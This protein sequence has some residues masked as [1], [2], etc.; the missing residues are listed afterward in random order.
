MADNALAT[1]IR[2]FFGRLSAFQ[3]AS[4]AA[5]LIL[6]IAGFIYIFTTATQKEMSVLYSGLEQKEASTIVER[7]KEMNVDYKLQDEGT[8]ILVE[9]GKIHETRLQLAGEGL[10]ET[11]IVGYEIFDRTN[12]GM[13]EFVQKVNYRRALEGELS[14]TIGT[15]EEIEKVRVHIVIPEK[16]LFEKDQKMPTASVILNLKSGRSVSKLNMQGIQ[17]LVANSVEGMQAK[18]VSVVDQR[19]KL[20]SKVD[21]KKGGIAGM[22]ADQYEQKKQLEMYLKD[23]AQS[24]LQ[25]V[26]GAGNSEVRVSA[27][28]DF[29]Q[30][31]ETSTFYDPDNVVE[32]SVQETVNEKISV[33]SLTDSYVNINKN[34]T[35]TTNPRV[36]KTTDRQTNTIINNEVSKKVTRIVGDIGEIKRLTVTAIVNQKFVEY[37]ENGEPVYDERKPEEMDDLEDAI[38]LAIGFDN[39]QRQDEIHV[40]Q[41]PFD[42]QLVEPPTALKWWE[43]PLNRKLI[44]LGVL[45]LITVLVLYQILRSR[46]IKERVR[47]A[48]SLPKDSEAPELEEKEDLED[49]VLE[50]EDML[51]LPS[52]MPEQLLL[53]GEEEAKALESQGQLPEEEEEPFDKTSLA[54][55]AKAKLEESPDLTEEAMLKLE[56]KNKVQDYVDS[57]TTDA[58][59]LVRMFMSQDVLGQ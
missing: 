39:A 45:I 31:E 57:D 10:P 49:I 2:N 15:M 27:E 47:M 50:E 36:N 22:S 42:T 38:K 34:E 41:V 16:T 46:Q 18:N 20:L 28:L 30:N 33:D 56:I 19:G 35:K 23:K 3:K 44:L 53:E 9:K 59:K 52:E 55:K 29:S 51:M 7:L 14:K 11:G 1:Q 32:R 17:N 54:D 37:N 4:I 40:M 8:T 48:L 58:V 21:E 5:V 13:S 12:L 6:V 25:S 43:K 24:M 26:L